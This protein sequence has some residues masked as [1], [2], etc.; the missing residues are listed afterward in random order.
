[1]ERYIGRSGFADTLDGLLLRLT[2]VG[3]SVGWF[4][5]LWGVCAPALAAGLALGGL[6]L[7]AIR[8]YDRKTLLSRE[9]ALRRRIGGELA[10]EKL[11]VMDSTRAQFQAAMWLLPRTPMTLMRLLPE[12]VLC[13][14]GDKDTLTMLIALHPSQKTSPQALVNAR[15]A[16]LRCGAQRVYCCLTAPL[17]KAAQAYAEQG[18]P[19][20]RLVE[21]DELIALAGL[22][23]PATDEQLLALKARKKKRAGARAWL[24][25]VLAP[26]RAKR[27]LVYGLG[28]AALYLLTGWAYYPLPAVLCLTLCILSRSLGY[29]LTPRGSSGKA[30]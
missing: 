30:P 16:A 26:K 25:H 20:L 29:R 19:E 5:F 12:G 6:T 17:E 7:L 9:Q 3:L 4:V 21:R 13:R 22:A 2:A 15:R 28:M 14:E 1:M 23:A 10:L 18:T 27:Y 11:L 8:L 24:C